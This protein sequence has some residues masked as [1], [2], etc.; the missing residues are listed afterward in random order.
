MRQKQAV[1]VDRN[2]WTLL[3]VTTIVIKVVQN[4]SLVRWGARKNTSCDG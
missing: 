3:R 2:D 4:P 1:S